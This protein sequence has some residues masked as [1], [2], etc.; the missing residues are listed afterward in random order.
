MLKLI[1][2][3]ESLDRLHDESGRLWQ[4]KL[5][6]TYNVHDQFCA[7]VVRKCDMNTFEDKANIA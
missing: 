1:I 2:L 6:K 4:I 7:E 5:I 3:A